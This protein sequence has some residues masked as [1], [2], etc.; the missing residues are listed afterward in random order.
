MTTTS[1]S[2]TVGEREARR[3]AEEARETEWRAPSFAKELFLGRFQL[4]LIHPHPTQSP[5]DQARSD[6]FLTK[7][8][9]V[10]QN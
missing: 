2:P 6:T 7:L 8:R 10:C 9:N 3:V 1:H 5:A 4:E